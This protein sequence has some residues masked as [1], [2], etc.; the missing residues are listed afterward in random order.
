MWTLVLKQT[1]ALALAAFLLAAAAGGATDGSLADARHL[2]RTGKYAEAAEAYGRQAADDA[3]AAVGLAR[4]FRAQGRLDDARRALEPWL[5]RSAEADTESARLALERGDW[6]RAESLVDSA[7]KLAPEHVAA[8]W[9]RVELHDA[10][11]RSDEAE[12][13]C[14]RLVALHNTAKIGAAEPL[15]WIARAAARCAAANRD[16]EQFRLLITEF[17]PEILA[18]E[19]DFWPAHYDAG[20]LLLAKHN[21]GDAAKHLKAALEINPY[22]AEVHVA[23][24]ELAL[25]DRDVDAAERAIRRALELRPDDPAAF[26][27]R[28]DVAWLDSRF[29]AARQILE[30]KVLPANPA[31]E[32]AIGRLLAAEIIASG[33]LWHRGRSPAER[34]LQDAHRRNPRPNGVYLAAARWLELHHRMSE[35][36]ELLERALSA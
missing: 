33:D 36:E 35:A 27:A 29:D 15:R 7:L 16:R 26:Q 3:A 4:V 8:L 10:A 25:L 23:L 17:Y 19:P 22:A 31:S 6:A 5:G 9:L 12:Q 34:L 13:L 11:G 2:L 30:D 28:A 1:P 20:R 21:R 32:P 18:R 14:R 24:A